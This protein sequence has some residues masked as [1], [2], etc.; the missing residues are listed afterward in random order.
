ME[1]TRGIGPEV[2]CGLSSGM[3]A[4]GNIAIRKENERRD[5]THEGASPASAHGFTASGRR[6]RKRVPPGDDSKVISP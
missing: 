2:D 4:Y 6:T 5:A 1:A 3:I